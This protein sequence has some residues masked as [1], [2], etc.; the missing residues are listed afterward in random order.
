MNQGRTV[1]AQLVE[2]LPRRAFENAVERYLLIP[3]AVRGWRAGKKLL[4]SAGY[5]CTECG[6]PLQGLPVLRCPECGQR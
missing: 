1:F 3:F 2:L 4:R 5:R 6:Y